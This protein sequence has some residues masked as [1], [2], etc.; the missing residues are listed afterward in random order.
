M[1]T[2][3][4]LRH[5]QSQWN[6][7]NRFTGWVDVALSE[8]G[9]AEA[10]D[11]GRRLLEAGLLPDLVH[12]SL[13]TRA[14]RTAEL[15]LASLDRSWVP[16]TRS[17]RLNERHYGGLQGLDKAETAA[18][19]GDE[20]VRIWRRSYSVPPPPLDEAAAKAQLADPRYASLPPES[21]PL[22]ECLAD[23]V[24]RVLPWWEDSAAPILHAGKTLLVAAHGNSLRALAKHLQ[25][26]G[27]DEI[28]NLEIATGT[29]KVYD[30]DAELRVRSV[31][32]LA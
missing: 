19:H 24:D 18:K 12:T 11:A 8:H 30:L 13:Q 10:I 16:V 32:D 1:P 14:I 9:E 17:W 29:P 3:V 26:I 20:Q 25:G 22:G 6:L 7:E 21:V 15:A 4:L 2:L 28:M 5:G 23:V 31:R 27:D